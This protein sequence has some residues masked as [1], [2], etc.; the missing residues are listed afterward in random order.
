MKKCN[1]NKESVE[2]VV[3]L[4]RLNLHDNI[5]TIINSVNVI[6]SV[7]DLSIRDLSRLTGVHDHTLRKLLGGKVIGIFRT[8]NKLNN[9]VKGVILANNNTLFGASDIPTLVLDEDEVGDIN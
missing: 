7:S 3:N 8:Y 6:V 5:N 4:S 1:K 2:F 9:F